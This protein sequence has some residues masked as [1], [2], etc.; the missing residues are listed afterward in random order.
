MVRCKTVG[1]AEPV[2]S[3]HMTSVSDYHPASCLNTSDRLQTLKNFLSEAPYLDDKT[4]QGR[5]FEVRDRN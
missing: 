1:L 4:G 5:R 3:H 2:R